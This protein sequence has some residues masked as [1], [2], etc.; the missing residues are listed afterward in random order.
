[1]QNAKKLRRKILSASAYPLDDLTTADTEQHRLEQLLLAALVEAPKS[2][3]QLR[4]A[5]RIRNETLGH[6]L[7]HLA[8]QGRIVHHD[9]LWSV[10]FR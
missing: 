10:P 7:N 9:G 3:A 2:R 6:V 4:H 1:L 5:L 8:A